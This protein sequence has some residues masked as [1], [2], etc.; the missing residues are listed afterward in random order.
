MRDRP[1]IGICSIYFKENS[2]LSITDR[3]KGMDL[4]A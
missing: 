2:I 4:L 1:E 3:E